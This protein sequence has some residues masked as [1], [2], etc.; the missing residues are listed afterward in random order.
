MSELTVLETKQPKRRSKCYGIAEI[1][2]MAELI[3]DC[4]NEKEACALLGFKYESWLNFKVKAKHQSCFDEALIRVRGAKI[5]ANIKKIQA[6]SD[7]DWR[8]ADKMLQHI[9]NERFG[10]K[11]N[12][13]APAQVN[14]YASIGIDVERL[15]AEGYSKAHKTIDVQATNLLPAPERG[16][17]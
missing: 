4:N 16:K 13:A 7:K 10:D 14:V 12:N 2:S 11:Q 3:A 5:R 1:E 8:A 15:L 6:A 17:E 9:D